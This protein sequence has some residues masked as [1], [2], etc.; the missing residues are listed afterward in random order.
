MRGAAIHLVEGFQRVGCRLSAKSQLIG[1]S[2]RLSRALAADLGRAGIQIGAE[3]RA[4]DLGVD[5]AA[6]RAR[7]TTVQAKRLRAAA[8][9]AKRIRQ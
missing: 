4:R 1:S 6:G 8:V 2:Q 7:A 3:G 5:T 9:R